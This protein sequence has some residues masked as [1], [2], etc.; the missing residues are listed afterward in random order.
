MTQGNPP[1]Q[2]WPF[3]RG[4]SGRGGVCSI[5][6]ETLEFNQNVHLVGSLKAVLGGGHEATDAQLLNAPVSQATGV[7]GEGGQYIRPGNVQCSAPP[8]RGRLCTERAQRAHSTRMARAHYRRK[9]GIFATIGN[10]LASVD[11]SRCLLVDA[12][13]HM[14]VM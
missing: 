7:G 13:L 14:G 3:W 10:I 8:Q 11:V 2:P 9:L 6:T 4:G 1:N 5:F 12:V